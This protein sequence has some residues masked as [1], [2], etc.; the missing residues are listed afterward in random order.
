MNIDIN[1]EFR[2]ILNVIRGRNNTFEKS[3]ITGTINEWVILMMAE[4]ILHPIK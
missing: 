2:G 1:V 4:N 3:F